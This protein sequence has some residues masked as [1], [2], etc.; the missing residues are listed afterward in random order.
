MSLSS[1]LAPDV[2]AALAAVAGPAAL[3]WAPTGRIKRIF[4]EI[5]AGYVNAADSAVTMSAPATCEA[6]A[7]VEAPSRDAA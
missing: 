1:L 3:I 7:T 5:E 6:A 2:L 4:A